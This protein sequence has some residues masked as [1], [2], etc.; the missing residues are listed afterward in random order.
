MCRY[1]RDLILVKIF[2][3]ILYSPGFR[4]ILLVT[5]TLDLLTPKANQQIYEPKY[6]CDQNWPKF[7]LLD[8]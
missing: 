2:T 7:A 6:I 1:I 4:V 5:L 3:N 8:Q